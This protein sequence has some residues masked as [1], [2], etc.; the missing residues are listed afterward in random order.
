MRVYTFYTS[1]VF[2]VV[3]LMA[4]KTPYTTLQILN[5][6]LYGLSILNHAKFYESSYPGKYIVKTLDKVTAHSIAVATIHI[7]VTHPDPEPLLMILYWTCLSWI[8]LVYYVFKK[9]Y[10]PGTA[11]EP[12]H[13]SVHI[14]GAVGQ[15]ALLSNTKRYK[16]L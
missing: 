4:Q 9:S 12:W 2:G 5:Q 7:A 16:G 10:L 13:A 11:W 14:A 3:A 1:F 6:V 15:I 8:L